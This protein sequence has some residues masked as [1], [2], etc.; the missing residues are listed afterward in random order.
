V[1]PADVST[2]YMFFCENFNEMLWL[3]HSM[4]LYQNTLANWHGALWLA[5][6]TS[7]LFLYIL[8]FFKFVMY[9][10]LWRELLLLTGDIAEV[11]I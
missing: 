11:E 4:M 10:L 1:T 8:L 2:V 7:I 3:L 6:S 9:L 5:H